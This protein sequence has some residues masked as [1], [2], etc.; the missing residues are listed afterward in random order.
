MG[1]GGSSPTAAADNACL[2]TS[3][4]GD[5]KPLFCLMLTGS[6]VREG[7]ENRCR[8]IVHGP[9]LGAQ[10]GR[11][12]CPPLL[13]GRA[14]APGFWKHVLKDE[15]IHTLSRQQLQIEACGTNKDGSVA[16]RVRNLSEKKPLRV[17]SSFDDANVP[18]ELAKDQWQQLHHGSIITLNLT[19]DHALWLLFQD[20][21]SGM[22]TVKCFAS[23]VCAEVEGMV[24]VAR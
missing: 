7:I 18:P 21:G 23:E 11:E 6:S 12:V 9:P 24:T 20:L 1:A 3:L 2:G 4:V 22:P 17:L 13:I 5:S 14:N 16:F 8:R 15:V 19:P 10:S